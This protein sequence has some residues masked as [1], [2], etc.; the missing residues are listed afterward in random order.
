MCI[1]DRIEAGPLRAC[2]RPLAFVALDETI[3]M[4]HLK[5]HARLPRPAVVRALQEMIEEALLQLDPV[6]GVEM[7]P[8]LDPVRLEP[9]VLRR[10]AHEALEVAARVQSLAAPVRGGQKGNS[11]LLPDRGARLVIRI[12][13]RV[14]A[15]VVAEIAAIA[16]ELLL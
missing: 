10:R 13:Q 11:D 6:V 7:G 14:R 2:D 4:A 3:D 9:F 12:I 8:V 5:L 15:D 16:V 1:R